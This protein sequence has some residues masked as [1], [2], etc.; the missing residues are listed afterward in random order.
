KKDGVGRPETFQPRQE[1]ARLAQHLVAIQSRDLTLRRKHSLLRSLAVTGFD[2]L[3][4]RSD[5]LAP[6]RVVRN[7]LLLEPR[8]ESVNRPTSECIL[9]AGGERSVQVTKRRFGRSDLVLEQMELDLVRVVPAI[10][11]FTRPR[12]DRTATSDQFVEHR[13]RRAGLG[14]PRV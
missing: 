12:L 4:D 1:L 3:L 11:K 7:A 10:S 8:P 2:Q 13:D 14:H 6:P 5:A 9:G